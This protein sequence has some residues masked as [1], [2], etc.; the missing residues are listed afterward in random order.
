V[1]KGKLFKHKLGFPLIN[2][3]AYLN[4]FNHTEINNINQSY[5]FW[6]AR[7]VWYTTIN[8]VDGDLVGQSV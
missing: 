6:G 5:L 7:C 4:I 1:L 3:Y 2:I 8:K